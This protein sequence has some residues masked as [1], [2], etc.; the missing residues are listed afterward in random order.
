MSCVKAISDRK[1]VAPRR[2]E[3]APLGEFGRIARFFAPLAGPGAL[4]LLDD[5]ALIDPEA[6]R[7][8]V[9]TADAIVA[10][11]HFLPNDPPDLVARKLLRV[12]LSDLAAMGATPL[13][14][15]MTTALPDTCGE[16]WLAGFSAGL[17][18]DQSEFKISLLGGDSVATPGPATLSLTAIGAIP[19]GRA[20]RRNGALPGDTI[21]VTGTIG[22]AALGLAVLTG[23]L[24]IADPADRDFLADRYRVP[25]PR[26]A[27]GAALPG[28]AHAMQDVS[29]GLVADLGHICAVSGV[30]GVID[31]AAVPL[32]PAARRALDRDPGLLPRILTGGDDYELLFT[33][34]GEDPATI[35]ALA[36]PPGPPITPIG[37]IAAGSGVR[38]LDPAGKDI[39]LATPGFRHF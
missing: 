39:A 7:Q 19:T 26:L 10:G 35:A 9:V 8:L 2:G 17:A 36:H 13:Y 28:V 4:G 3:F 22:D 5:A 20:V 29:D 16:E 30:A 34:S 38:V 24:A 25:R 14:Y 11:I 6:G 15:L 31:A 32:S 23:G 18:A 27:V 12:N 33:S 21:Y 1:P 37:R